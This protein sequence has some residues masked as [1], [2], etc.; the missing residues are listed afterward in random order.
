VVAVGDRLDSD[1]GWNLMDAEAVLI[2]SMRRQ[3]QELL[4]QI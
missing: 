2:R 3:A 4:R 1:P